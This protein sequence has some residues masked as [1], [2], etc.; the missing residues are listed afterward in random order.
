MAIKVLTEGEWYLIRRD[1]K[2][3]DVKFLGLTLGGDV[4]LHVEQE[5]ETVWI[6]VEDALER[7]Y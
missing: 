2:V 7:L 6:T 3:F 1:G 4:T 5:D